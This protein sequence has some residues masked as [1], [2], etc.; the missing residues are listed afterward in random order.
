MPNYQGLGT[1]HLWMAGIYGGSAD[2]QCTTLESTRKEL[3]NCNLKPG[4]DL[5]RSLFPAVRNGFRISGFHV[6]G[7]LAVDHVLLLIEQ[8]SAAGG[9]TLEDIQA[10]HHVLDH[11]S[12]NPRPDQ[13]SR[14]KRLG[15]TW[16]CGPKYIIRASIDSEGYDV[17]AVSQW[18]VPYRSLIDAGLKPGFHTDGDQ[19]G[20]MVF[21]YME[22]AITRQ[23]MD[24]RAWNIT[25]AIDRKDILRAATR[26]N[27]VNILRGDQLGSIEAG[28]WADIIVIDRDYMS[29]PVRE[30]ADIKVLMTMVGGK[31]LYSA[32]EMGI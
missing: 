14:G 11:C 4:S 21:K 2:T 23:D 5:W 31:I 20:P 19:G 15:V 9:M 27:A 29:I 8:A 7:D 17:E 25:E 1:P 10:R 18:V 28:K 6:H 26:W 30:I 12:I 24:G 3:E 13:I 32:P 16:T 22:V